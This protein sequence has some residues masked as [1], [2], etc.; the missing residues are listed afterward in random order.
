[1]DREIKFRYWLGKK[2]KVELLSNFYDNLEQF[3]GILDKDG[4]EIY[5][6]DY[7]KWQGKTYLVKFLVHKAGFYLLEKNTVDD[8]QRG[9]RT[10]R[11]YEYEIIKK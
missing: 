7:I 2:R 10:K 6:N 11:Q 4:N 3:T 8:I 1:M 9:L 5:E